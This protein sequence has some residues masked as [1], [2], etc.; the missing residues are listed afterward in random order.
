MRYHECDIV[1]DL[2]RVSVLRSFV[3]LVDYAHAKKNS[4]C[5]VGLGSS[6]GMEFSI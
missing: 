6:F 4:E 3:F 5:D 1:E 2:F